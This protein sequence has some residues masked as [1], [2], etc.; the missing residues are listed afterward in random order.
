MDILSHGFLAGS[1]AGVIKNSIDLFSYHVLKFSA[2]RY[3]DHFSGTIFGH[4]SQS[5][6]EAVF[7]LVMDIW[8]SGF[9][10]VVFFLLAGKLK[11]TNH[12]VRGWLYGS[13]LW[14]IF[15]MAGNVLR[16][17][18]FSGMMLESLLVHLVADSI[19]GIVLGILFF[20]FQDKYR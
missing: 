7:A 17:P 13:A 5:M 14:F 9:L 1:A 19:Y 3:L 6:T 10:G 11:D 4:E 20:R 18:S 16:V 2:N 8:F 12:L 15:H